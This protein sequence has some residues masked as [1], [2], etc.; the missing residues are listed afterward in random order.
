AKFHALWIDKAATK[1]DRDSAK[2]Q[3]DNWLKHHKKTLNDIPEIL[4]QA[5]ADDAARGAPSPPQPDPRA[6]MPHPYRRREIS[7]ADVVERVT[8]KYVTMTEPVA[9]I[10]TLW[11]I[12]THVYER[13]AIAPRLALVSEEPNS[14]KS[15][16]RKVHWHLVRRPNPAALSSGAVLRRF[17]DQG[18]GTLLLDEFNLISADARLPL[19]QIWN[20]GH[21]RGEATSLM[22]KG[23]G[24]LFNIHAPTLA[25]GL[26][27]FMEGAQLT[28]TYVLDLDKYTATTMP[29]RDFRVDPDIEELNR[30]YAF[31]SQF[32]RDAKLDPNP[33]MPPELIA[34][35]AD[36]ARGLLSVAEAC[37]PLWLER[38]HA[39]VTYLFKKAMA[40]SPKITIIRHGLVIFDMLGVDW[41]GSVQFNKELLQLALPDARWTRYRGPSGTDYAHPIE[42]FEQAILLK[43]V[44]IGSEQHRVPGE[45]GQKT[46][47][48]HGYWRAQFEEALR[49][50]APG[51][52]GAQ[53]GHL[54]L[55]T[56]TS[57]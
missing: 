36:N 35:D 18:F 7:P 4:D 32:G 14:G 41:I 6:G 31:L 21:E 5:R 10:S 24:R 19:L 20:L 29:E 44:G 11:A 57:D 23:Q 33:A 51:D 43:K 56:P 13:F 38:A 16:L 42:L 39:A 52:S 54:R 22:D 48:L 53:R 25:A 27:G 45:Q 50:H 28:R 1:G 17:L 2:H 34:R 37:G 3:M 30:V 26:G 55:I 15:T 9:V 47:N 12:F 40:E 8:R 46:R 49:K